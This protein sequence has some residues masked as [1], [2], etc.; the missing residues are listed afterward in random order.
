MTQQ[1]PALF[2]QE[3]IAFQQ[4]NRQ[5][6]RVVPL[7]QLPT[8]LMVWFITAAAAAVAAFLF[9][10]QY[11]RKET[12]TGYLAPASGTARV[13]AP[14]QG[15]VSAVHVEQGQRV[16]A[17]QPLLSVAVDQIAA[18]GEDVN[19]SIVD[20]LAQQQESLTR[21]MA[22]EAQRAAS[23]RGRIAAQIRSLETGLGHLGA[24]PARLAP[25]RP[26]QAVEEPTG[27]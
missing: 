18:S 14:R 26:E 7:Q 12:V 2:R 3:V 1:Q 8:R 11:A 16:E 19:A 27:R 24:P 9:F 21:Q 25:L 10:A 22:A 15:T 17:G 5:W 20:T 4:H 13:F 23:E 6:G